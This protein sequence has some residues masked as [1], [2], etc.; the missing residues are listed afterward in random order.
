MISVQIEVGNDM[1]IAVDRTGIKGVNRGKRIRHM[2]HVRGV[3]LKIHVAV[4][5]K[6][7]EI[8]SLEVTSD[9]VHDGKTKQ[10]YY[11]LYC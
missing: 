1:V 9:E 11:K 10:K 4:D 8:I 5:I 7:R 6:N 2:C 3:Y